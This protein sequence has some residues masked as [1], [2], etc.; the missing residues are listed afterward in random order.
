MDLSAQQRRTLENFDPTTRTYSHSVS[1]Y[2]TS[3]CLWSY[4]ILIELLFF[5]R[6]KEQICRNETWSRSLQRLKEIWPSPGPLVNIS[7]KI[8]S[9]TKA[10]VSIFSF[11]MNIIICFYNKNENKFLTQ[12][13]AIFIHNFSP[14]NGTDVAARRIVK[15]N[16]RLSLTRNGVVSKKRYLLFSP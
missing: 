3:D 2:L 1:S 15:R 13:K 14:H 9:N 5:F 7:A 4:D 11:I 6:Y 16:N 12:R 8:L 10:R